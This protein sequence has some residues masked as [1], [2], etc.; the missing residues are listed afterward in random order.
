[1]WARTMNFAFRLTITLSVKRRNSKEEQCSCSTLQWDQRW[2]HHTNN[3]LWLHAFQVINKQHSH[4]ML[5]VTEE[6]IA[7]H[8][9]RTEAAKWYHTFEIRIAASSPHM[10]LNYITS[11]YMACCSHVQLQLTL[12]L[13]LVFAWSQMLWKKNIINKLFESGVIDWHENSI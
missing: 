5:E 10:Q 11:T 9:R 2:S 4:S 3:N 7:T 13:H 8:S 12:T 6:Q 1:M